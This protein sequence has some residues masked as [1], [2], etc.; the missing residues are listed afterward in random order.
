MSKYYYENNE[1]LLPK[2]SGG[3]VV[4][5][6]TAIRT[7]KTTHVEHHTSTQVEVHRSWSRAAILIS[8]VS[9]T[10]A[11]LLGVAI[12]WFFFRSATASGGPPAGG[13]PSRPR[14]RPAG[15]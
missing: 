15:P 1:V 8:V 13:T 12:W 2:W 6:E 9:V 4:R 10:V 14:P 5:R 3:P 11:V 7:T